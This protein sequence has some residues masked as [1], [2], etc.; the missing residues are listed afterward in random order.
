MLRST[1]QVFAIVRFDNFQDSSVAIQNRVTVTKVVCDRKVAD[2]EV[3]RLNKENGPK[4][5][6]YFC[7]ATR[8]WSER[9]K[10]LSAGSPP[11]ATQG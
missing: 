11:N 1:E 7:Q 6:I 10:K 5:C 3:E 8:L 9:S 4:S 2:A